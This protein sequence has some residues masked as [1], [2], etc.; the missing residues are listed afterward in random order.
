MG[1]LCS[2]LK[3]RW[4]SSPNRYKNLRTDS[5]SSN[6][7]SSNELL[8]RDLRPEATEISTT[9]GYKDKDSDDLIKRDQVFAEAQFNKI[10]GQI[11][12]LYK[13][14]VMQRNAV[15]NSLLLFKMAL[16]LTQDATITA[17][18]Q[19]LYNELQGSAGLEVINT[20]DGPHKLKVSPEI[21]P[22]LSEEMKASIK[23]FNSM[24][25]S[26][27][28]YLGSR[29]LKVVDVQLKLDDLQLLP[30]TRDNVEAFNELKDIPCKIDEFTRVIEAIFKD[31]AITS[32]ILEYHVTVLNKNGSCE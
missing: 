29:E 24:L 28:K 17:C 18:F 4:R 10:G 3:L 31:I 25:S 15:T 5:P 7:S 26:C 30:M 9:Y 1:S 2:R 13:P 14:V 6:E 20:S 16:G 11:K 12:Q 21:W 23:H 27:H 19:I 22:T 32:K 8:T